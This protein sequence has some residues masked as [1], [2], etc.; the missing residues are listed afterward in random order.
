MA[1]NGEKLTIAVTGATGLVGSRLV[2]KLA[3]AGHKVRVLT[4][5]TGSA[6]A[7][8]TYPGLEF[9]GPAEWARGVEGAYGVVNLAGEPIATRWT[10]D[11]KKAIK[12]SRV[13]ATTAV[14]NAIKAAPADK[15]PKVLVS[16][17]AVG[18]YGISQTA[19]YS[20]DSPSGNDYLAE[21]CRA[22][23]AAALEAQ[24]AGVRVVIARI[25]IVLAPEGGA[26]GKMLP[27]FQ[28]FAGGPLGSGKQWMSWIHRDDLVDLIT[29]ALTNPAYAGV[30]N[31]TAPKPVR[32]SELCSALGNML[33]RPSW[34]PV[35]EFALMTLLGEGA[36][37]VLDG[38]R[39][40][41]T[42]TQAAGY[43][44]KYADIGDALRNLRLV[45]R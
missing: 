45:S 43:R 4:R 21:V 37:V 9:F 41:P 40:M 17:S 3:A 16:A 33:G 26:L 2:A 42:R 18:Y 14:V 5:N 38:Q 13:G 29:Q 35:P 22:W 7:K 8:L 25:G 28:I 30:Y 39:V 11:L 24:S 12:S 10:D 6:R 44:F 19:T 27:V 34:L 36:S 1:G 31:A 23:E 20:E 32:M 15:R